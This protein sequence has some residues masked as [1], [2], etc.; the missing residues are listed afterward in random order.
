MAP[1][2]LSC[3]VT[4]LALIAQLRLP[5]IMQL[6]GQE[7]IS[8]AEAAWLGAKVLSVDPRLVEPVKAA[9]RGSYIEPI[10]AHT[11]LNIGRLKALLGVVPPA[12]KWTI[13]TAFANPQLLAGA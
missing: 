5:G 7:D 2:P 9:E 11:T 6:S 10:P 8:Y 4:A 3:A 13:E 12:V 1:I